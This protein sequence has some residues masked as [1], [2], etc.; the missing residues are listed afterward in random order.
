LLEDYD[1]QLI[2]KLRLGENAVLQLR[3][4]HVLSRLRPASMQITSK[5]EHVAGRLCEVVTWP[6][7]DA[8]S[9]PEIRTRNPSP[10]AAHRQERRELVEA[11]APRKL[12]TKGNGRQ[13]LCAMKILMELS[14]GNRRG[15]A[16]LTTETS[17]WDLGITLLKCSTRASKPRNPNPGSGLSVLSSLPD[18]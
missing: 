11:G 6:L 16:A 12:R 7:L 14:V 13:E 1:T 10:R 8:I 18:G 4:S 3:R 2:A 5:I 17:A 9:Q 15:E